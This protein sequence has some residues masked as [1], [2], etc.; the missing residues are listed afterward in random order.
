MDLTE[1]ALEDIRPGSG[2]EFFSSRG[3]GYDTCACFICGAT[4]RTGEGYTFVN[5]IAAF[6]R[7]KEAGQRVVAMFKRGARLDYRAFEPNWIQVK[8]GAC[9]KHLVNLQLLEVLTDKKHIITE[10]MIHQAGG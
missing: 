8:I 6:V 7:T 1:E 5:N 9:D 2:G 3:I 4:D 10:D